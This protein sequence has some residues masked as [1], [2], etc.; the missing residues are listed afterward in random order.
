[1]CYAKAGNQRRFPIILGTDFNS[2]RFASLFVKVGQNWDTCR[3]THVG[4]ILTFPIQFRQFRPFRTFCQSG[5]KPRNMQNNP[6]GWH[7]KIPDSISANF[8]RICVTFCQSGTNWK[9]CKTTN[10]GAVLK[11]PSQFPLIP[12]GLHHVLSKCD[13]IGK[14]AKWRM[15]APF[16]G[17]RFNC[18]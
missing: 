5:T 10:V 9:T 14:H 13:K 12:R 6:H 16:W 3:M 18:P 1:M 2:S 7:F 8:S 11:F 17:Y 15:A 4:A